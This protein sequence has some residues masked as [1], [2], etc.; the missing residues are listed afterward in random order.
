MRWSGRART[1]RMPTTPGSDDE[2]RE[3]PMLRR[4]FTLGLLTMPWLARVAS[5]APSSTLQL[6]PSAEP[7]RRM[8]ITGTVVGPD[9]ATPAPGVR[10]FLYQ[11]DADG[12]YNRPHSNP[13]AA[14]LRGWLTTDAAG[15][16]AIDTIYPGHYPGG[17][18]P[19][20]IHVHVH[21]PG[22]PAHWIED[23][24]F[25]G[26]PLLRPAQRAVKRFGGT[27]VLASGVG[28]AHG[29]RDIRIDAEVASTNRLIDGW[30]A[31]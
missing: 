9:G 21:A 23:F 31:R 11:T 27:L 30:Y 13:R 29:R 6:A 28:I 10:L 8:R 15:R 18:T 7:G 4:Q 19:S 26:D 12:L 24:L 2:P 17:S 25:A 3:A 5:A 16:Y 1:V 14:V 22:L 20:H